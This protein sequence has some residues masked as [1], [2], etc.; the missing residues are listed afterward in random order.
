M[1]E[2]VHLD[3]HAMCTARNFAPCPRPPRTH[4]SQG[5][6]DLP[7]CR[8]PLLSA[9]LGLEICPVI[10]SGSRMFMPVGVHRGKEARIFLGLEL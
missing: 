8:P 5:D 1:N 4:S 6:S 3:A 9:D 7:F 10:V 2:S